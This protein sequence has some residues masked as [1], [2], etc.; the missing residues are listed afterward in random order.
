MSG[1]MGDF[2]FVSDRSLVLVSFGHTSRFAC[3]GWTSEGMGNSF[4]ERGD[5][6][7]PKRVPRCSG[8]VAWASEVRGH[9]VQCAKPQSQ[10]LTQT[11]TPSPI[12]VP[13]IARVFGDDIL[14]ANRA[15]SLGRTG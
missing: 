4:D 13:C 9:G 15:V 2:G 10:F 1:A 12:R 11:P 8:S 7:Q 14:I 5:W 6:L 3:E